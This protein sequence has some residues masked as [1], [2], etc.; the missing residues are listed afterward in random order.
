[1]KTASVHVQPGQ[2]AG[3]HQGAEDREGRIVLDLKMF[4]GA[5]EPGDSVEIEGLPAI[6]VRVEGGYHGDIATCAMALNAVP[7]IRAAPP[8]LRTML[9]VIPIHARI[10]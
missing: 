6:K 9:D 3:I 1:V 5:D 10:G 2:V 4:V 8:G 7:S